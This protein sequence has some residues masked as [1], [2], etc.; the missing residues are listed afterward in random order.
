M[1]EPDEIHEVPLAEISVSKHN[2][3][4]SD[5]RKGL[6]ELK[7]SIKQLGLLQPVVLIGRFGDKPYKLLIGQRRF[8]A[9]Q[10]L[11]KKTIRA[12]FTDP[13]DDYRA[14]AASLG[15]NLC[16]VDINHADAAKAVTQ[17]YRHYGADIERV[18][19]AT[20]LSKRVI[21][22][23]LRI[24]EQASPHMKQLLA[25]EK[26]TRADVKRALR[27]GGDNIKKA[28]RLLDLM[29]TEK[30]TTYQKGRVVGYARED[31]KTS[32]EEIVEKALEPRVER[33]V[34]VPLP[35]HVREGLERA[36]KMLNQTA[37]EIASQA[38]EEWLS[39]KGFVES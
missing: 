6:D 27:A 16:R 24:E 9:H 14:L 5:R 37:E 8:L 32:A 18:A 4:D 17:L 19:K 39:D 3:R 7:E 1:A 29:V 20:G 11:G 25:K 22:T 36:V 26:V 2:V 35:K 12:A 13:A 31:S 33:T 34:T 21:N 38:L 28:E 30:L 23:Y 15:E 10:E